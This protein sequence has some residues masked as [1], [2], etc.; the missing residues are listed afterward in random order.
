MDA[1][2]NNP[3]IKTDIKLRSDQKVSNLELMRVSRGMTQSQLAE[4]SGIPLSTIQVYERF[5]RNINGAAI[6]RLLTLCLAL[7]CQ[8]EDILEGDSIIEMAKTVR[9]QNSTD[10]IKD[11]TISYVYPQNLLQ[12]ILGD[13]HAAAECVD[14]VNTLEY[15]FPMLP[16]RWGDILKLKYQD[17][18]TL[19]QIGEK[20]QISKTRIGQLI[21]FAIAKLKAPEH[22]KCLEMGVDAYKAYCQQ[23]ECEKTTR[24][25]SEISIEELNLSG[26]AYNALMR[27]G[28]DTVEKVAKLDFECLVALKNMSET[29]ANEVLEKIGPYIHT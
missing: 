4:K 6:D 12:D 2:K 1:Q 21:N 15:L 20:Y 13:F 8:L 18:W 26:R 5:A 19:V 14:S 16:E 23:I 17:K 22:I 29:A 28:H 7:D 10:N 3:Q 11:K 9:T 25:L 27:S 24:P